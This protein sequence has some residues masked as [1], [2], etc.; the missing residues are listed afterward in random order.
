MQVGIS[1]LSLSGVAAAFSGAFPVQYEH[2]ESGYCCSHE[3][4]A[5]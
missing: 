3:C 1:E 5:T 2:Q 4:K